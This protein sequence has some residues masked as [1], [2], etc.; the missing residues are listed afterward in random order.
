M[1]DDVESVEA[2]ANFQRFPAWMW[3]NADVLDFV[4][5]L[6]AY[7]DALGQNTA[8]VGLYVYSLNTSM[9]AVLSYLDQVDPEGARRAR[10]LCVL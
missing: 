1:S 9:A 10:A 7:N 5:W 4:S 2:L 6:R 8:K 3:R